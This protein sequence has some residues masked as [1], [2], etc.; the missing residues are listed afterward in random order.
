MFLKIDE[1]NGGFLKEHSEFVR[2]RNGQDNVPK[3]PVWPFS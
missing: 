3:S 2:E 1:E